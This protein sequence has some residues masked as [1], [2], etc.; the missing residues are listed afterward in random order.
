MYLNLLLGPLDVLYYVSGNQI[1]L[2]KKGE[3][4]AVLVKLK[5][6][7]QKKRRQ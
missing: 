4:A 2:M 5:D 3:E 6:Q 1:V 7:R